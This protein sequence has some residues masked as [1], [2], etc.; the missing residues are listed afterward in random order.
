[1]MPVCCE[2]LDVI[3]RQPDLHDRN[4][5]RRAGRG[6]SENNGHSGNGETKNLVHDGGPHVAHPAAVF[7]TSVEIW[8]RAIPA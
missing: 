6:V 8:T 5:R 1:M 2:S 3:L 4:L 7:A